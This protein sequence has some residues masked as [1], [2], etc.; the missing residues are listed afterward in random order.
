MWLCASNCIWIAQL[1]IRHPSWE[2]KRPH[3]P[4]AV[5]GGGGSTCVLS[6]W[7]SVMIYREPFVRIYRFAGKLQHAVGFAESQ[8]LHCGDIGVQS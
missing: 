6:S 7:E 3:G 4:A 5:D 1:P 2:V 8:E